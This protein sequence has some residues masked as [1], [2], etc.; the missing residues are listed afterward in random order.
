VTD[1]LAATIIAWC[2]T[3]TVSQLLLPGGH[4][5]STAGHRELSQVGSLVPLFRATKIDGSRFTSTILEGLPR[6]LVFVDVTCPACRLLSQWIETDLEAG[7]VVVPRITVCVLVEGGVAAIE[8]VQRWGFTSAYAILGV[9][10]SVAHDLFGV[11]RMPYGVAVDAKDTVTGK[12]PLRYRGD[13]RV[14]VGS[15]AE[16]VDEIRRTRTDR[17]AEQALSLPTLGRGESDAEGQEVS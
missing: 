15:I 7:G 16:R 6:L 2:A 13:A 14:L 12:A 8:A 10:G 11:S 4:R 1:G 17:E 3:L 9:E 5:G